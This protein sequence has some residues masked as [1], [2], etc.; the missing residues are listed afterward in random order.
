MIDEI[1]GGNRLVITKSN[2]SGRAKSNEEK[3]E[4]GE[5][6]EKE[7][8]DLIFIF[9]KKVL[10]FY[11]E[12][13]ILQ[14]TVENRNK[15]ASCESLFNNLQYLYQVVLIGKIF[16]FVLFRFILFYFVLFY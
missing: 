11:I 10:N 8:L 3:H 7:E 5:L 14:L 13:N 1:L 6:L 16:C 9:C 2:Y 4:N 15:F 12:K